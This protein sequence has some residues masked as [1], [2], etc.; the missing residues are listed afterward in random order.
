MK[1]TR[2]GISNGIL[3]WVIYRNLIFLVAMAG[4]YHML[5]GGTA[6]ASEVPVCVGN[7]P[8]FYYHPAGTVGA[9]V[10]SASC[11]CFSLSEGLVFLGPLRFHQLIV[12][13]PMFL[14]T[15]T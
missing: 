12:M 11:V 13:A 3:N 1:S 5:A 15:P 10:C 9:A 6:L 14:I 8:S 2:R 4:G 7:C